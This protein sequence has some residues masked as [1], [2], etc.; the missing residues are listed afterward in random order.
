MLLA[1]PSS[2]FTCTVTLSPV[3]PAPFMGVSVSGEDIV[4]DRAVGGDKSIMSR[5]RL[6]WS[7]G[8]SV[9]LDLE[10]QDTSGADLSV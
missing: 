1:S 4:P 7:D 3:S 9:Q 10:G 5:P 2:P 6:G 8:V